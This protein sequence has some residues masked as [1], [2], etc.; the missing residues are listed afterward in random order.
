MGSDRDDDHVGISCRGCGCKDIRT[1]KTMRVRD[2]MIRRY[3]ECRHCGR[4]MTT[5]EVTTKREATRRRG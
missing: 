2:G 5:H 4:T 3:R 1:T